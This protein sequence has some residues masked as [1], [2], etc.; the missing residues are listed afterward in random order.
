MSAYG[1]VSAAE[2]LGGA[3]YNIMGKVGTDLIRPV[4]EYMAAE[5]GD[6]GQPL[7]SEALLRMASNV[8][9]LSNGFKAYMVFKYGTYR[10]GSGSTLINDLP[11]SD[12]LAVALGIQPGEMDEIT[13]MAT[14]FKD[15]SKAVKE[16]SKVISNYR[17][18]MMHR[19]DQRETIQQEVNAFVRLLPPDVRKE[20]LKKVGRSVN[21][22]LYASFAERLQKEQAAQEP[23]GRPN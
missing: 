21:P 12:A 10:T 20:A 6:E 11:S 13:A 16:A 17:V 19:P 1:E 5:S 2:M 22:S 14:Y 23:N 18:D 8:S 7:R 9:T 4:I 15:K 3:T